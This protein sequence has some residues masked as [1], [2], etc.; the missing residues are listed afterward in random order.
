M[1]LY[2]IR[3]ARNFV[4][5]KY[6]KLIPKTLETLVLRIKEG[7]FVVFVQNMTKTILMIAGPNGA[8][9]PTITLELL[10]KAPNYMNSLMHAM[11]EFSY[12]KLHMKN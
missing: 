8:G 9:K 1:I 10:P 7:V 12:G 5:R 3:Q 2:F 11:C 6:V 4:S